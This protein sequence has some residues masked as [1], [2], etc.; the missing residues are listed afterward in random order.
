MDLLPSYKPIIRKYIL[1]RTINID[2]AIDKLKAHLVAQGFRQM[3]C[4]DNF[5]RYAHVEKTTTIRLL[6]V[7]L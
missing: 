5:C 4:S 3:L 6:V 2:G 7:L 1:R